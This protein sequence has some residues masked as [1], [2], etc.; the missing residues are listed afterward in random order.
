MLAPTFLAIAGSIPSK[1]PCNGVVNFKNVDTS[2]PVKV[3]PEILLPA[4]II[5]FVFPADALGC[6]KHS[7]KLNAVPFTTAPLANGFK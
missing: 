1:P 7:S 4:A 5:V 2:N 6:T 3:D